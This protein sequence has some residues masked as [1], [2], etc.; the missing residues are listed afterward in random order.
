MPPGFHELPQ[1]EVT[2]VLPFRSVELKPY[3][4]PP[5]DSVVTVF[6][7]LPLHDYGAI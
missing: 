2:F 7:N 6:L 4:V 1:N 3:V 5:D